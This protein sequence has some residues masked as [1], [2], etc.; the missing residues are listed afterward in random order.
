VRHAT[1]RKIGHVVA[2][3]VGQAQD[4]LVLAVLSASWVDGPC[5]TVRESDTENNV[6]RFAIVSAFKEE[7]RHHLRI[8]DIGSE[9]LDFER[10]VWC[11]MVLA[12][13]RLLH[14]S[15][16]Q[17][18]CDKLFRKLIHQARHGIST[19][20]ERQ[21]SL[22]DLRATIR[23]CGRERARTAIQD[24][25]E[26]RG[27][28]VKLAVLFALNLDDILCVRLFSSGEED[29]LQDLTS[30]E[31]LG[32]GLLEFAQLLVRVPVTLLASR[33]AVESR[34]VMAEKFC[35][36]LGRTASAVRGSWFGADGAGHGGCGSGSH[37]CSGGYVGGV[38]LWR[39]SA[40]FELGG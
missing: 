6:A 22:L 5:D 7:A 29:F 15:S 39:R 14:G 8:G 13:S 27:E 36:F 35:D 10:V 1:R 33:T 25:L 24:S 20:T 16:S 17:R 21:H 12:K 18:T 26:G 28:D 38:T 40:R 2:V 31:K 3:V 4:R 11:H 34:R 23:Q 30:A 37:G 19:T 32:L 9:F